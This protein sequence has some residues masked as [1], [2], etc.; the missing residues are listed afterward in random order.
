MSSAPFELHFLPARPLPWA[1]CF[2]LAPV[3]AFLL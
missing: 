1:F 2:A 3:E